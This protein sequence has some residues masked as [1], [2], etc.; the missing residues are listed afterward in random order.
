MATRRAVT[1]IGSRELLRRQRQVRIRLAQLLAETRSDAGVARVELARAVGI[2]ASYLWKIESGGAQPSLDLVVAIAA[3]LGSDV[4]VRLFPGAGPRL[5]DRFQAPM[6]EELLRCLHRRW[7]GMPE[8][9][10]RR[11]H[12]IIDLVLDDHGRGIR[13]ACE[14]HSE[15]RRLEEALRRAG[16]KASALDPLRADVGVSRMLLLRSTSATRDVARSFEATLAAAYPAK[17]ADAVAALRTEAPWPGPSIVW[18]RLENG[19][20]E[21][22]AGP[23]R[24]VRVGR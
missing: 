19:R 7:R 13:I 18:V 11:A 12:G 2:D 16:E 24:G 8:V 14:C 1:S 22:L 5:V 23:P 15:L 21:I 3:A 10:V 4:G 6:I 20:A 9:P 17:S